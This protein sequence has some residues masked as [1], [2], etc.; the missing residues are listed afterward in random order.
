MTLEQKI[1]VLYES[2]EA[3]P[4]DLSTDTA[5]L[6]AESQ[7]NFI[8]TINAH[9]MLEYDIFDFKDDTVG[10]FSDRNLFSGVR[11]LLSA[12]SKLL[13]RVLEIIFGITKK[14]IASARDIYLNNQE[15]LKKYKLRIISLSNRDKYVKYNGYSMDNMFNLETTARFAND[16]VIDC[17]ERLMN[18]T[19]AEQV[20]NLSELD[21][22]GS[23]I[24]GQ[25][26]K[27]LD[28]LNYNNRYRLDVTDTTFARA[29]NDALFGDRKKRIYNTDA[30]VEFLEQYDGLS[31]IIKKL[32]SSAS[33]TLAVEL[34]EIE[35][36]KKKFESY[37]TDNAKA[38]IHQ[39]VMLNNYT[40]MATNDVIS[41][42][43]IMI[44]YLDKM[45]I[46]AKQICI[47]AL[48]KIS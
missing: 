36:L 29:L 9:I 3:T 41:A 17:Y 43:G 15:F 28:K 26:N 2:T 19:R 23:W 4:Y 38:L 18:L 24:V 45:N 21:V 47:T 14:F 46:Q 13:M 31:S 25:R 44:E 32:N 34:K 35:K 11:K 48:Q 12:L 33:K 27:I 1:K 30:A 37:K 22:Y 20:L 16:Q 10:A 40:R 5:I 8:E 42:I 6:Y 39:C 7:R